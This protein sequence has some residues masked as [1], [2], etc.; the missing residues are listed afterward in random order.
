MLAGPRLRM[1]ENVTS[2]THYNTV[3]S[4]Y[5]Y[6]DLGPSLWIPCIATDSLREGVSSVLTPDTKWQVCKW[7]ALHI[8]S[9][10]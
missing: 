5:L 10:S 1:R 7:I 3:E 6:C 2:T 8:A 4:N 9:V